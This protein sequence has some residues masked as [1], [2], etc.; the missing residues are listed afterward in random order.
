MENTQ[1]STNLLKRFH[2]AGS[3]AAR[4]EVMFN[5]QGR[6]KDGRVSASNKQVLRQF[7]RAYY[8]ELNKIKTTSERSSERKSERKS[9][10]EGKSESKSEGKSE[11]KSEG[12]S[13]SKSESKS[14][15]K[16]GRKMSQSQGVIEWT[17]NPYRNVQNLR[18]LGN[19]GEDNFTGIPKFGRVRKAVQVNQR[20][21]TYMQRRALRAPIIPR[22]L[23]SDPPRVLMRG[24]H[25]P[26][27]D[28]I[29]KNGYF[30]DD[31]YVAFTRHVE[32]ATRFAHPSGIVLLLNLSDIPHGTPYI[33]FQSLNM[34]NLTDIFES[35]RAGRR[36]TISV[37]QKNMQLSFMEEGEVLLPPGRLILWRKVPARRRRSL[38]LKGFIVWEIQYIPN[39]SARSLKGQRIMLKA[40]RPDA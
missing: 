33:W 20:V 34:K 17:S 22:E 15:A 1:L 21:A 9:K 18:R 27:A 3:K 12:K 40:G 8:A 7:I 2:T 23:Q 36:K 28:A 10:S 25:G 38:G 14:I 5:I 39:M 30:V 24:L 11:S 32:T 37:R 26:F 6:M 19:I 35:E 13:E 31:G 16:R 4:A 29:K